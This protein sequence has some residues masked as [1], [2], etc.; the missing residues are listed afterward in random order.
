MQAIHGPIRS[1]RAIWQPLLLGLSLAALLVAGAAGTASAQEGPTSEDDKTA[2]FLGVMIS[3]SAADFDLNDREQQMMVQGL[4][5]AMAGKPTELDPALYGPKLQQLA[6]E[7]REGVVQREREVSQQFLV[8][9]AKA[10]GAKQTPSGLIITEITVGEGPSPTATDTVRV[11]YHGTLRDGTVFDSSVVRGEP[12]EFPLNRVIPCWTEGV[13]KMK[14]GGKAKLVCPPDIAYQD[15]GA[16]PAIPGG[17]AL[18]FEVE[19]LEI[20]EVAAAQ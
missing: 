7:R 12:A 19:L 1:A 4:K 18:T 2:Y 6:T 20:V 14:V 5:E 10:P 9:A 13:S 8:D 3:K 11:H 16:P 17:A 15:R